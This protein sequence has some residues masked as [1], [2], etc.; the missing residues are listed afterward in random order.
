MPW[1]VRHRHDYFFCTGVAVGPNQSA[2]VL[3]HRSAVL[4]LTKGAR[5]TLPWVI[6]PIDGFTSV[7][8]STSSCTITFS[9]TGQVNF[10]VPKDISACTMVSVLSDG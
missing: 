9:R 7:F 8:H 2:T 5:H 1:V 3:G 10:V 4:L 6:E